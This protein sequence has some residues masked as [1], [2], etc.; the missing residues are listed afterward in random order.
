M[1]PA[2]ALIQPQKNRDYLSGGPSS[3]YDFSRVEMPFNFLSINHRDERTTTSPMSTHDENSD[4][5]NRAKVARTLEPRP[6]AHEEMQNGVA[7]SLQ[8][9][10]DSLSSSVAL[11]M[12]KYDSVEQRS[13]RQ[14]QLIQYI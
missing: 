2:T 1:A 7:R 13:L 5:N 12:D 11:L 3:N 14:E 4:L 8:S 6:N 10:I 9:Q